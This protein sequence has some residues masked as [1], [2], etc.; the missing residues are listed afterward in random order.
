MRSW[1]LQTQFLDFNHVSEIPST[2]SSLDICI[3][4][5]VK[6][7]WLHFQVSFL[8]FNPGSE[9]PYSWIVQH[10]D[11][12]NII[13]SLSHFQ[14]KKWTQHIVL[15]LHYKGDPITCKPNFCILIMSVNFSVHE[16]HWTHWHLCIFKYIK[17]FWPLSEVSFLGFN[18]GNQ[19]SNSW[20]WFNT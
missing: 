7:F 18:H 13:W 2:W 12:M 15:H 14:V 8:G 9:N 1:H 17:L 4:L 3:Y 19:M 11:I 10:L 5:N 20:T 6:L 16:I